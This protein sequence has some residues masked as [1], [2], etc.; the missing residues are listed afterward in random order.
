[1]DIAIL[2]IGTFLGYASF[3]Y[4]FFQDNYFFGTA[5]NIYIGASSVLATAG[6][7]TK[8]QETLTRVGTGSYLLIVPLIIGSLAFT[9]LTKIR[10]AARYPTA[11]LAGVG[12]GVLF[13]ANIRTQIID[14]VTSSIKDL[15]AATPGAG[16][17]WPTTPDY[18]S[19][20]LMIIT[21]GCVIL[22]F[23]YSTYF[24]ALTHEKSGYLYYLQRFGKVMF[25]VSVGYM[26]RSTLFTNSLNAL[27]T[28]VAGTITQIQ[29]V[30]YGLV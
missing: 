14:M 16:P 21:S 29:E 6:I 12:V 8:L 15:L 22:T 4:A 5:E 24:S 7:L 9:R 18:A 1:M 25:M 10:W 26:S 28:F 20:V 2:I 23:I 13:G 27:I 3:T 30:I 17:K 11:I 19:V